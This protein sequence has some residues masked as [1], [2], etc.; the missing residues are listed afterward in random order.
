MSKDLL[1]IVRDGQHRANTSAADSTARMLGLGALGV[2]GVGTLLVASRLLHRAPA[3]TGPQAH[4]LYSESPTSPKDGSGE[5]AEHSV[6]HAASVPAE[7]AAA[8]LAH[9][10]CA[11]IQTSSFEIAVEG[12]FAELNLNISKDGRT[13]SVT[14]S[15]VTV[16]AE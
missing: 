8:I 6:T 4:I 1:Q 9:F 13:I 16:R 2:A 15:G 3:P 14:P 5:P 10:M 7:V 11:E 12:P